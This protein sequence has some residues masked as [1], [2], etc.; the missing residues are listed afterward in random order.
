MKRAYEEAARFFRWV[1]VG[2]MAFLVALPAL[3]SMSASN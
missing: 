1:M 2:V 3:T